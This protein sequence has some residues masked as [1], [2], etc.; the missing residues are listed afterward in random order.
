MASA[1]TEYNTNIDNEVAIV[2][3]KK[4]TITLTSNDNVNF[5][6][7]KKVAEMSGVVRDMLKDLAADQE[8]AMLS[9]PTVI[10]LPNVASK[11]LQK[12]IE[13]CQYHSENPESEE[14]KEKYTRMKI[15]DRR[16]V[17]CDWDEAFYPKDT[18]DEIAAWIMAANF[19]NIPKMQELGCK[20]FATRIHNNFQEAMPTVAELEP[21]DEEKQADLIKERVDQ[22]NVLNRIL[23]H[24]VDDFTPEQK[25]A[26]E[27]ENRWAFVQE[28]KNILKS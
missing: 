16:T 6:V 12:V 22:A 2:A 21:L 5:V 17:I 8:E 23:L 11:E 27:E 18:F 15:Q 10:P 7:E 14:D 25:K 13:Y 20:R 3:E 24:Q 1:S 4:E 9:T 28:A 19:L 26:I